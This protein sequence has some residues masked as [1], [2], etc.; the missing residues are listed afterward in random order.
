[1]ITAVLISMEETFEKK[2]ILSTTLQTL[3]DH[4]FMMIKIRGDVKRDVLE[5]MDSLELRRDALSCR[6]YRHFFKEFYFIFSN[7]SVYF[8]GRLKKY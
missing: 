5:G 2:P 1:M 7:A 3:C 6:L 4:F 8:Y